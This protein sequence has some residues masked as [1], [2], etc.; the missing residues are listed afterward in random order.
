MDENDPFGAHGVPRPSMLALKQQELA[1]RRLALE[2][3][4]LSRRREI[5]LKRKEIALKRKELDRPFIHRLAPIIST[6]GAVIVAGIA[7]W[8]TLQAKKVEIDAEKARKS[9]EE[10]RSAYSRINFVAGEVDSGPKMKFRDVQDIPEARSYGLTSNWKAWR[11]TVYF[12]RDESGNER[13]GIVPFERPPK[14]FV[15]LKTIDA[16]NRPNG[17]RVSIAAPAE[18]TTIESFVLYVWTWD[19]PTKP[20]ESAPGCVEVLWFAY[21]MPDPPK[22][23]PG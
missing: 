18:E 11:K 2:N 17:P 5:A 20:L 13:P 8:T 1:L 10:A 4:A 22:R 3:E 23:G 19:G 16:S 21:D 9:A 14:V 15:S 7:G 6:L 12:R